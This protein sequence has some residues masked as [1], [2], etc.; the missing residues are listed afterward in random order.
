MA[1]APQWSQLQVMEDLQAQIANTP[2]NPRTSP[3]HQQ[4]STIRLIAALG[5]SFAAGPGLEPVVD[6]VAMRSGANYAH[7][8][9]NVLSAELIDLICLRYVAPR[10]KIFSIR[11]SSQWRELNIHRRLLAYPLM[12]TWS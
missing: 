11:L 6:R 12:R 9:A 10:R 2:S 3:L 1:V 5:S 7:L 8:V 4:P